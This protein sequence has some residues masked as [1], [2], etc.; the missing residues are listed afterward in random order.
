LTI[1]AAYLT[2]EGVV[3]GADSTITIGNGVQMMNHNQKVFEIGQDSTFGLCTFGAGLIGA[4]SHRTIAALLG[5]WVRAQATAPDTL[6]VANELAAMALRMA[7]VTPDFGVGYYVGGCDPMTREPKCFR[8]AIGFDPQAGALT[9]VVTPLQRGANFSGQPK[10]FTRLFMGI[11]NELQQQ[12]RTILGQMINAADPK[13]GEGQFDSVI[14]ALLPHFVAQGFTDLPVRDAIDY[15]HSI[16]HVTIKAMKFK[17]GT[18]V[19]GGLVEIA[20]ITTDRKFRWVLHK[21][22]DSAIHDHLNLRPWTR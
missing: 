16:L 13:A 11:D 8:V 5:D 4:T 6:S 14:N 1:A 7:P 22:F 12:L 18:P 2:S 21:G 17:F 3:L 20:V 9:Q 19:C 15:L 10:F